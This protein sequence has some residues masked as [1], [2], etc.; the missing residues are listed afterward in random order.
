MPT[1]LENI[2]TRLKKMGTGYESELRRSLLDLTAQV[3]A[4]KA[5][6]QSTLKTLTAIIG[7]MEKDQQSLRKTILSA[8]QKAHKESLPPIP[9]PIPVKVVSDILSAS[10]T[11]FK[12]QV[13]HQKKQQRQQLIDDFVQNTVPPKDRSLTKIPFRESND[14]KNHKDKFLDP[15][16]KFI[17]TLAT[18]QFIRELEAKYKHTK[19]C[20]MKMVKEFCKITGQSVASFYKWKNRI[21]GLEKIKTELDHLNTFLHSGE[22]VTTIQVINYSLSRKN[23]CNNGYNFADYCLIEGRKH[24]TMRFLS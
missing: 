21:V 3:A 17:E 6:Q 12:I 7:S 19:R 20:K 5:A 18:R 15:C 24:K 1:I 11:P 9:P 8:I 14:I 16:P 23:R 13:L 4:T 10:K 22:T 2:K